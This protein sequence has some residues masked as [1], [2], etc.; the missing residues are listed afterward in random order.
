M[1][2]RRPRLQRPGRRVLGALMVRLL[3]V[4]VMRRITVFARLV[5]VLLLLARRCRTL[6]RLLRPALLLRELFDCC[7]LD[8]MYIPNP[9][10]VETLL[11]DP[12]VIE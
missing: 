4:W 1:T 10:V 8:V 5:S 3:L 2:L 11:E 12:T 6:L 9:T 7:G